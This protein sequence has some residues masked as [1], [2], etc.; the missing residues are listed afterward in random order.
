MREEDWRAGPRAL[1][2]RAC[3]HDCLFLLRGISSSFVA[4]IAI[5]PRSLFFH[6]RQGEVI[7]EALRK[8][9]RRPVPWEGQAGGDAQCYCHGKLLLHVVD[10]LT[11]PRPVRK[12]EVGSEGDDPKSKTVGSMSSFHDA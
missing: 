6:E 8:L 9:A 4:S 10:M 11:Y 7:E 3:G 1:G 2:S 12:L 5:E